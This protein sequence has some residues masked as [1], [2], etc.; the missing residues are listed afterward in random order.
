MK[1]PRGGAGPP[2]SASVSPVSFSTTASCA[3]ELKKAERRCADAIANEGKMQKPSEKE[4]EEKES[5]IMAVDRTSLTG[6]TPGEVE[7]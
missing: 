7:E 2:S 4:E 5:P 3:P 6:P 1:L